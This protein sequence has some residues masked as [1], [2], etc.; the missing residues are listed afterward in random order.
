MTRSALMMALFVVVFVIGN[1]A[2]AGPVDLEQRIPVEDIDRW[3]VERF[4][5]APGLG[6]FVEGP[7]L[8]AGV[9]GP[10]A[11]DNEGNAYVAGK[12]YLFQ[13]SNDG[14]VKLI[15]GTPGMPGTA[16]GPA[17]RS[18]FGSLAAIAL[19]PD[20]GIYVVDRG[21]FCI[22]KVQQDESGRW[23]V[24][25]VAGVPGKRGHSD[26]VATQSLLERPDALT[27]DSKGNLY[28]M[29]QD[30]LRRI[31][32]GQMT[33]LNPDGGTGFA[34]GPLKRARFQRWMG[35]GP[36]SCAPD[37]NLYIADRGNNVFRKVNLQKGLVSTFAGGP[38][39]GTPGFTRTKAIDGPA[40]ATAR[41]FPGGGPGAVFFDPAS[42][43]VYTVTA[44][45]WT[46]RPVKDGMVKSLGPWQQGRGELLEG[47]VLKTGGSNT[48]LLG[49]D[50]Q[51]R[52]YF[53][54]GSHRGLVRRLYRKPPYP[55][56][57]TVPVP[58]PR[59]TEAATTRAHLPEVTSHVQASLALPEDTGR[60]SAGVPLL[61]APDG[62]Y[63]VHPAVAAGDG[64]YLVAW[65][66]GYGGAGTRSLIRAVVISGDG[67]ILHTHVIRQDSAD[68]RSPAVTYV[69]HA[70]RWWMAY[71]KRA[72]GQP[73][74]IVH[75]CRVA[76]P[77]MDVVAD[78]AA[79]MNNQIQPALA[80]DGNN[81]LMV[82][83]EYEGEQ[84]S[85]IARLLAADGKA[86]T[87]PFQVAKSGGLPKVVFDGKQFVIT[88]ERRR[89]A[90][91]RRV[92]KEGELLDSSGIKIGGLFEHRPALATDGKV[93]VVTAARRPYP[94]PWGWN[95]P[96]AIAIG[97]FTRG[98]TPDI[99]TMDY[100]RLADAGIVGVVDAATWKGKPGWPAGIPGGFK[101]TDS[102]YWPHLYSTVACDGK[103]YLVAWVR[104]KMQGVQLVDFDIFGQRVSPE[105]M[106]TIE[107]PVGLVVGPGA[108]SEPALVSLGDGKTLLVWQEVQ[109]DGSIKVAACFVAGG[110]TVS[111]PRVTK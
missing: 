71:E 30:W 34:D 81:L 108:R 76:D 45:E 72:E 107:K 83:S 18:V 106:M 5:G 52:V 59:R 92:T 69:A 61:L 6:G 96:G 13:V 90:Y 44:D 14:A 88:Y 51:G 12:T 93:T 86:L 25:T 91:L 29:D 63:Q 66:E 21:N 62:D 10:M 64:K 73:N 24:I 97:R 99:V 84:Y 104:A 27:F 74:F 54:D 9:P 4:M 78:V 68:L 111:G 79:S 85:I 105:T 103:T 42:G 7:R 35:G 101:G 67:N 65:Q 28:V 2:S 109:P 16:D 1:A 110:S 87:G 80:S 98:K 39:R 70:K 46:I 23:M 53:T 20:A 75:A 82:W 33:T 94:N 49:V 58:S 57:E 102:G 48:G 3:Y 55:G 32:D 47:P 38:A 43:C 15:A 26:G 95:G 11:F 77:G 17:R 100:H 19:G 50:R 89:S 41:F 37:D 22:K 36:I 56:V 8:Q 31:K 60:L 40:M